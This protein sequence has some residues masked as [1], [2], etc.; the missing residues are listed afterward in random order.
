MPPQA[1]ALTAVILNLLA[2]LLLAAA[3]GDEALARQAARQAIE[4][5]APGTPTDLVMAAQAAGLGLAALD[6]LRLSVQGPDAMALRLRANANAMAR[7]AQAAAAALGRQRPDPPEAPAD[8]PPEQETLAALDEAREGVGR[9]QAEPAPSA[10]TRRRLAWADAMTTVAAE[11]T[12]GLA[13]LP[14][15][16]RRANLI[17]IGALTA[18]ARTLSRPGRAALLGSTVLA[19]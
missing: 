2:P 4:A 1:D 3:N 10:D 11:Y 16:Q 18:T 6:T 15:D 8:T 13:A 17:R 5:H 19:R 9:A 7:T 14:P 12:A